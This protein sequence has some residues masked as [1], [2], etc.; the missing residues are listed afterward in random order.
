MMLA[1][2]DDTKQDWFA[3]QVWA[4]REV[5]CAKHLRLRGYELLVPTHRELRRWSDRVKK[6]ECALF[7]GYV[8]C[9]LSDDIA[10]TILTTPHVIRI[11][12]DGARALPIPVHEIDAIRRIVEMGLL[13]EPWQFLQTGQRVRIEVGPLRGTEGI[14]VKTKNRHR[15]IVSISIL[16][17]SVA[18]E[19]EA[20]WVSV[21]SDVHAGLFAA[22]PDDAR[23]SP[24]A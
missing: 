5:Q 18:V 21:H 23:A 10:G 11:V 14:V 6:V 7:R 22:L 4:G 17:R 24:P 12:G 2:P 15:L 13:V 16:Q 3:I 19:V 9:R 1:A 8:F 20:D